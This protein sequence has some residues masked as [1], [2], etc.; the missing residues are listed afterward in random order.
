MLSK[1]DKFEMFVFLACLIV[2]ALDVYYW[3]P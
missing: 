3:R 1:W 2:V